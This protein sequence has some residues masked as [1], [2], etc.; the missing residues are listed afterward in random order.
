MDA[1]VLATRIVS[2]PV[3]L[4]LDAL[5]QRLVAREDAVR[6]QVAR[7]LPTVGVA[8]DRA[9][10]RTRELALARAG[11]DPTCRGFFDVVLDG[12]VAEATHSVHVRLGVAV[13]IGESFSV[14]PERVD[15]E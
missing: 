14:L 5:E 8:R 3:V 13:A 1:A 9:P 7:P 11:M 4:P 6:Q 12:F 10:W 15:R 2:R